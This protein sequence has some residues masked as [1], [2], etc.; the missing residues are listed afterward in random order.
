MDIL[1][2]SIKDTRGQGSG[3]N[4]PRGKG[5]WSSSATGSGSSPAKGTDQAQAS[6]ASLAA[7]HAQGR[8]HVQRVLSGI[9]A[10]A[11]PPTLSSHTW[12]PHRQPQAGCPL[13]LGHAGA[14]PRQPARF[15]TLKPCSIQARRPYQQ[16]SLAAGGTSVRINHGAVYPSSQQASNV[17]GSWRG[18]RLKAVPVPRQQEPTCGA[19]VANG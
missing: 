2:A 7:L 6:R 1:V 12:R 11:M 4:V 5:S 14:L 16:A 15:V 18:A 8:R 9:A 13:R 10:S 3:R 17:Q 19:N